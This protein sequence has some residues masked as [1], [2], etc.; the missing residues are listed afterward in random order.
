LS[1]EIKAKQG[2]RG[3]EEVKKRETGRI[4]NYA[5]KIDVT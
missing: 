4:G 5:L 3:Q 1:A 2:N